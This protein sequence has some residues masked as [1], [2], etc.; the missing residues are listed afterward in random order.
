MPFL[1]AATL[2][3]LPAAPEPTAPD[4][5][6]FAPP[7]VDEERP[8]AEDDGKGNEEASDFAAEVEDNDDDD[9]E[10]DEEDEEEED[11][12]EGLGRADVAVALALAASAL[13]AL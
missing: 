11:G 2:L 13:L 7:S 9:E 4:E 1:A 12:K 8:L 3:L 5:A 6:R 10:E